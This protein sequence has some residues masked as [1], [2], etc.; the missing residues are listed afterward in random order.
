MLYHRATLYEIFSTGLFFH[1]VMVLKFENFIK[2]SE[3][4]VHR[5]IVFSVTSIIVSLHFSRINVYVMVRTVAGN[6]K[7]MSLEMEISM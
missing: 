6:I 4:H 1:D 3:C 2:K 5:S 7:T